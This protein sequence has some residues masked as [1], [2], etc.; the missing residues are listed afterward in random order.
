MPRLT[1]LAAILLAFIIV[2]PAP[3][4]VRDVAKAN[5]SQR[6][7]RGLYQAAVMIQAETGKWPTRIEQIAKR[8]DIDLANP[9][10]G[11]NPGYAWTPPPGDRLDPQVVVLEQLRDGDIA[12]DLPKCYADGSVH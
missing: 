7:M 1:C 2:A 5:E 3:A 8:A 12:D 9:L 11:D 6:K 4:G 10:T